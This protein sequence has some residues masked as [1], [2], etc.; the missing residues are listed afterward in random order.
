MD[1]RPN[2]SK[3]NMKVGA[4]KKLLIEDTD[5][6]LRLKDYRIKGDLNLR[7][8]RIHRALDIRDCIFEGS[9]DVRNAHFA[10]TVS[11]INCHFEKPFNSGDRELSHTTYDEDIVF[12]DSTFD[13]TAWFIGIQCKGSGSFQRCVFSSPDVPEFGSIAPR[14]VDFNGANFGKAFEMIRATFKG[15]VSF[16][17]LKCGIGGFF[18]DTTFEATDQ[19]PIDFVASSYGVACELMRTVF[20]GGA[21]FSGLSCGLSMNL[22]LARFLNPQS[23]INLSSISVPYL[24]GRGVIF[25]GPL[26]LIGIRCQNDTIFDQFFVDLD[27]PPAEALVQGE[28][29]AALKAALSKY[30]VPLMEG[31]SVEHDQDKGVW[32][33]RSSQ[34]KTSYTLKPSDGGVSLL[35]PS[36]FE[37][38]INEF[39]HS[40]FGWN[41]NL[42]DAIFDGS[43]YFN[44]IRCGGGGFFQRTIFN[45]PGE[46]IDFRF[47]SFNVNLQFEGAECS[48]L[49]N[50]ESST[51]GN[52][53]VIAEA[54]LDS[55]ID[56][57]GA[58]MRRL[59]VGTTSSFK[60]SESSFQGCKFEI[61]ESPARE[62]AQKQAWE[63]LV[64]AQNP[65]SFTRDLYLM[66]ERY[67][68]AAG[69]QP[70]ADTIYYAGRRAERQHARRKDAQVRWSSDIW[71]KDSVSKWATGY[72]VYPGFLVAWIAF[73][74][75]VGVGV[76]W[77]DGALQPA[78]RQAADGVGVGTY[79]NPPPAS[80]IADVTEPKTDHEPGAGQ[81]VVIA[82]PLQAEQTPPAAADNTS[83]L[84]ALRKFVMRFGY[85]L[86]EFLPL[87]NLHLSDPWRPADGWRRYYLALHIAV[88][89]VLIPLL[90]GAITGLLG[91]N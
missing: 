40:H 72:G 25:R 16:N 3:T 27:V 87:V 17:A 81:P 71:L 12:S 73:F 62:P 14:T 70:Q 37:G 24:V 88:G 89:W 34:H 4:F 83:N 54:K 29:S 43:V 26:Y 8:R 9:I 55:G 78:K 52:N 18:N 36:G 46:N 10:A 91:K 15:A 60:G 45:S 21:D 30:N 48:R 32:R 1:G 74:V 49:I 68:R 51:I 31:A 2:N 58:T 47:S 90:V 28:V 6:P 64:E 44:G 57:T 39:S 35:A 79:V 86:D 19:L 66:L 23:T 77:S 11:M 80:E 5:E 61:F 82:S 59:T 42:N 7:F 38:S 76:F 53:L 22:E 63:E 75:L 56:L 20:H 84:K 85:S 69:Q 65:R 13:N 41:L 33:I 67:Y 50:L